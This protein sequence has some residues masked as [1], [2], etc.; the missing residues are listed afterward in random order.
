M[1]PIVKKIKIN[2]PVSKVW[3]ALTDAR[4]LGEWTTMPNDIKPETGNEFTF[5]ADS[6]G[7]FGDWDRT[8][9]CK[10]KEVIKNKK[11]SY[12]WGSE[13]IKGE[14]LVSYELVEKGGVTELTLTHSG[15]ENLPEKQEY[16]SGGHSKGWDELLGNLIN[17]LGNRES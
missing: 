3:E 11:I 8:I 1:T 10:V 6:R 13:L 4:Q 16:W 2:A 15:W 17:M 5:K 7:D 12:T 14:T 9:R